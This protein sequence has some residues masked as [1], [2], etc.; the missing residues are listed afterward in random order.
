MSGG[1]VVTDPCNAYVLP[2]H[3]FAFFLELLPKHFFQ[4]CKADAHH[5][6][7]GTQRQGILRHLVSRNVHKLRNRQWAELHSIRN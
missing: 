1:V 4:R 3:S 2:H 6:Q 5:V 7:R